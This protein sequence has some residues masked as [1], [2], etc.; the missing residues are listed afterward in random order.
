[1]TLFKFDFE[2]YI[3]FGKTKTIFIRYGKIPFTK[4]NIEF[5]LSR[6]RELIRVRTYCCS[7]KKPKD[8]LTFENCL[9]FFGY[10]IELNIYSSQPYDFENQCWK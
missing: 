8:H 6:K 5:S 7:T 4:W 3:P 10:S 2:L 1:M 9:S